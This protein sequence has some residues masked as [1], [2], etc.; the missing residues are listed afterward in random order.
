MGAFFSEFWLDSVGTTF[1]HIQ[2]L[3]SAVE[4]KGRRL[5]TLVFGQKFWPLV[6]HWQKVFQPSVQ[7]IAGG[8]W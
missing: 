6:Y 2:L 4:T 7:I 8:V 5:K 1:G 3:N